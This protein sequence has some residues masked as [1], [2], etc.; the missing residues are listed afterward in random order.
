L[1]EKNKVVSVSD[2]E[3]GEVVRTTFTERSDINRLRRKYTL[4]EIFDEIN[5]GVMGFVIIYSL[6]SVILKSV[7][8]WI[9]DPLFDAPFE[10][11]LLVFWIFGPI[12]VLLLILAWLTGNYEV[13][14]KNKTGELLRR[15]KDHVFICGN[16]YPFKNSDYIGEKIVGKKDE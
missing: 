10:L 6:F 3:K 11:I 9:R 8:L 2:K 12:V 14:N 13:V 15:N 1:E 4:S 16:F 5:K 7:N